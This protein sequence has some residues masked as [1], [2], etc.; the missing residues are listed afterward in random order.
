MFAMKRT[1]APWRV[2]LFTSLLTLTAITKRKQITFPTI[3]TI[4]L[5]NGLNETSGF[6]SDTS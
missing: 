2:G 5:N 6:M 3:A 1:S 4:A